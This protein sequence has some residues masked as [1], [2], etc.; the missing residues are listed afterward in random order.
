MSQ[1]VAG[2]APAAQVTFEKDEEKDSLFSSEREE[3]NN[4]LLLE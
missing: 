3:G 1:D 2:S 4:L